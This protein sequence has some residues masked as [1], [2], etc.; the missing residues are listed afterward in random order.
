MTSRTPEPRDP[1]RIATVKATG[2]RYILKQIDFRDQVAHCRGE[3]IKAEGLST[4]HGPDQCIPL[5][6]ITFAPAAKTQEL[7]NALFEQSVQVARAALKPG[8]TLQVTRRDAG[9]HRGRGTRYS[10]P[11]SAQWE[12]ERDDYDARMNAAESA[13]ARSVTK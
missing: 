5:A 2:R 1:I 4:T 8:H 6:D 13:N 9:Q 12:R 10:A 7:V 11:G 3:V